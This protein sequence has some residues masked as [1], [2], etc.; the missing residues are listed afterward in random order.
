M[1]RLVTL[2]LM[3]LFSLQLNALYQQDPNTLFE[4]NINLIHLES[5]E[6][7]WQ[8]K[9]FQQLI[10]HSDINAGIFK[11]R[12]FTLEDFS[13][14]SD[15]P[16][17]MFICGEAECRAPTKNSSVIAH[18]KSIKAKV[19]A[20]EHRYYGKSQPF[21]DLS[22]PNLKHLTT[23]NALKDLRS[24]QSHY[25]ML[26]WNG[27]WI[28]IGGSYAGNLS[29][30]YSVLYPK[31]IVGALSSSAPVIAKNNFIEYDAHI[32]KVAGPKCVS[33]IL[34][35]TNKIEKNIN[36]DFHRFK[37]LFT[38]EKI[39]RKTDF[40]Y[41]VADISA[42]AVQYGFRD[43]FC[44]ALNGN[45]KV[46]AYA[47][48][49]KKL[50]KIWGTAAE[51]FSFQSAE[52]ISL[53]NHSIGIGMRQWIYQSCTEYGYW[54]NAH[55]DSN[56]RSRSTMINLKYHQSVCKRLFGIDKLADT[57][58]F[59]KV[60]LNSLKTSN[61]NAPIIMTNGLEDP[62]LQLSIT[63]DTIKTSGPFPNLLSYFIKKAAHCDDLRISKINKNKS[64]QFVFTL[65]NNIFKNWI[66]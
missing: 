40:M 7:N 16:V 19:I 57:S 2:L 50:F 31:Q 3:A 45:D 9:S 62:W 49:G 15:A 53:K 43:D 48:F 32:H 35:V 29:A 38:A 18:A 4:A 30:F 66:K 21:S 26:G 51:G 27:K 25:Q 55:P 20:I 24:V 11:Q 8:S 23:L 14:T 64:A 47:D 22:T 12:L 60:W 1:T 41:M 5:T 34:H 6:L 17:I 36:S 52:P 65:T 33:D 56:K 28:A 44:K 37:K 59:N 10:N 42:A 46:K 61:T 63:P 54:Q 39:I 58:A 13:E